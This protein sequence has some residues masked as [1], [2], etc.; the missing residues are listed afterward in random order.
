M[1]TVELIRL[2]KSLHI[3]GFTAWF[4]GMF[5]LVRIFVY[6]REA[7]DSTSPSSAALIDQYKIMESRAYRIICN[8]AMVVTWICGL[9]MLYLY[10]LDWLKANGWLHTKLALVVLLSGYMGYCGTIMKKMAKD[11]TVMTSFQFRLFNELPT[12]FLL[13]IVLLAVYRNGLNAAWTTGGIILF[14]G[15]LMIFAKIYKKMRNE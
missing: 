8:P 6:H 4:G 5:Y 12:I 2:F 7:I 11:K 15:A 13:S 1:E 14:A 10:G 9:A 3:I